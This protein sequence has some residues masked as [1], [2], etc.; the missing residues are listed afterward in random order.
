MLSEVARIMSSTGTYG[1]PTTYLAGAGVSNDAP[2]SRPAAGALRDALLRSAA[3]GLPPDAQQR[4][5][6]ASASL[7][8]EE[9]VSLLEN[10]HQDALMD[11]LEA[12]L[13]HPDVEPNDYHRFLA[14]RL[15][16]GDVV[17]TTNFD[18]LI[19]RA[20]RGIFPHTELKIHVDGT[21]LTPGESLAGQLVKIHGSF[22]KHGDPPIAS[23][24]S[25]VTTLERVALG[26]EARMAEAFRALLQESRL[27]VLG[28]SA[29][30]L[31]IVPLLVETSSSQPLIWVRRPR[32]P[33]AVSPK[34]ALPSSLTTS[35]SWPDKNLVAI[36]QGRNGDAWLVE[37]DPRAILGFGSIPVASTR[38]WEPDLDPLADSASELQRQTA[39]ALLSNRAEVWD[40]AWNSVEVLTDLTKETDREPEILRLRGW[41]ASRPK[42]GKA[43]EVEPSYARALE[44]LWAMSPTKARLVD[45]IHIESHIALAARQANKMDLAKRTVER[46]KLGLNDLIGSDR[47][48]EANV[49]SKV[50]A[51]PEVGEKP[52]TL[53]KIADAFTRIANVADAQ[54]ANP[55]TES[56]ALIPGSVPRRHSRDDQQS[57]GQANDLARAAVVLRSEVGDLRGLAQSEHFVGFT[58]LKLGDDSGAIGVH[59][60]TKDRS[61]R[62]GWLAREYPQACRNLALAY[63]RT[64]PPKAD[65]LLHEA[66]TRMAGD[67]GAFAANSGHLARILLRRSR[68]E[69]TSRSDL[70]GRARSTIDAPAD[71]TAGRRAT[72]ISL[73]VII[74]HEQGDLPGAHIYAKQL[75]DIYEHPQ[76][77][78]SF[79]S[80]PYAR[81]NL[82]SN[83]DVIAWISQQTG[84][85][86]LADRSAAIRRTYVSQAR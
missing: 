81:P 47:L 63:E 20:F 57:L 23:R 14:Q 21:T 78:K 9:I 17:V 52:A 33:S 16:A 26:L 64:D 18:D 24:S 75:L 35:G 45:T 6:T 22:R 53:V 84:E 8:F 71:P 30:D 72:W 68:I 41:V 49:I 3:R 36:L 65:A 4:L 55:F 42:S 1:R 85:S 69:P 54:I 10:A 83:L 59:T 82:T 2:S 79:E 37:G 80:E 39:I 70:L 13:N 60:R 32:G 25:I 50:R 31:D 76:F 86:T 15:A 38:P 62:L 27:I 7:S 77:R 51:I 56:R 44:K 48:D 58:S 43:N 40:L 12:V 67:P 5:V 61:S 34:D 74:A 28:Y 29:S 66:L 11:A 73:L 46:M 19:E